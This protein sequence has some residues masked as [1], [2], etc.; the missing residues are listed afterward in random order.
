MPLNKRLMM[1]FGL[2]LVTI[3]LAWIMYMLFLKKPSVEK[4]PSHPTPSQSATSTLPTSGNRTSTPGGLGNN[5][6]NPSLPTAHLNPVVQNQNYYRPQPVTK[7]TDDSAVFTSMDDNGNLRYHN[8][9]DGKFYKIN[10]NGTITQLSDQVFYNVSN[11]TWAAS[12]N[13]AVIEY[14]DDTKTIYNFDSKQQTT[15]PKHWTDFSFSPDSNTV[16][17][18]S[19]GLAPENRWLVTTKDDGT[20][21]QLI[22]PLGDNADKVTMTWSPSGQTVALSQTGEAQGADRKE[23]LLIGLHGENLKSIIVE[24]LDFQS[25]WSPT[26]QQ[27]LY[28]VDSERSDYKPELWI[29][30]AYGDSIG[31]AR[32]ML[33]VNTWAKK[34]TFAGDSTVI[35]GIPRDLPEGAGM[36]PEIAADT[37]DDLYR[38]DTK[39]GIR[40]PIALD[41]SY[42]IDSIS[43]DS[44]SNKVFFTDHHKTGAYSVG[45]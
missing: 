45:L 42:T 30:N 17:A 1:I 16:A 6:N 29:T 4:I 37:P 12:A 25:Q 41:Q 43:Y 20:G 36:S 44:A 40:T 34:C 8:A 27:L 9:A 26:G 15:L 18:K 21:T 2:L 7:V 11:V 31:S 22:E 19:M 39:T 5:P 35:C 10:P 24:G 32:R 23:V 28:S 33:E 14:P 3:L 13:K 38:I